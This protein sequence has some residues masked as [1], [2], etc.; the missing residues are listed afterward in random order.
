MTVSGIGAY[1]TT[2]SSN[3]T[4]AGLSIADGNTLPSTVNNALRQIM[5]DIATAG[6]TASGVYNVKD[7]GAVGDGTTNDTVR[8]ATLP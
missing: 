7:Y 4:I 3:T 1:S 5:A 2:P 8:P 6:G